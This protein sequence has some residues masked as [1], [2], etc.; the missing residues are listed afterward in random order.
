MADYINGK[1]MLGELV[2]YNNA[3]KTSLE[4]GTDKPPISDK[5]A[6]SFIQIATRLMNS[7]NFVGYSYRDEM[8]QAGI[9]KCI[10]KV[11]RFDP[12]V[13]PQCFAF[14]TQICWNAAIGVIK[15]EQKES[16]TK[17]RMVREKM[18]DEF[19]AHGVDFDTDAAS[20]GF[21]TFLQENDCYI[22]YIEARRATITPTQHSL[23]HRNKTPYVKKDVAEKKV[24][25]YETDLSLFED[26][27]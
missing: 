22:D 16:S 18:S 23:K 25:A 26:V 6:S 4:L 15:Q 11:H 8:I 10:E 13:S 1:E 24:N 14:F 2:V 5:L 20:N 9:L 17:A 3:Y 7:Y 19:V 27:V 21:V 12:E